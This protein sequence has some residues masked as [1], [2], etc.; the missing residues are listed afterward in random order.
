MGELQ[1]PYHNWEEQQQQQQQK[2]GGQLKTL[3][4]HLS[5]LF[6][7]W[8][9]L[10]ETN[11]VERNFDAFLKDNGNH[12]KSLE[13]SIDIDLDYCNVKSIFNIHALMFLS[14]VHG[15]F[16]FF[17]EYSFH[18]LAELKGSEQ[19][20]THYM[21]IYKLFKKGVE[22]LSF[23]NTFSRTF[24]CLCFIIKLF[25]LLLAERGWKHIYNQICPVQ[26]LNSLK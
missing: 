23:S 15:G 21:G 7:T 8:K 14:N 9:G 6:L 10:S 22:R 1:C 25:C 20:R 2:N 13:K 17:P 26:L 4:I 16:L 11:E 12:P 5:R 3:N 19:D 18:T 24:F